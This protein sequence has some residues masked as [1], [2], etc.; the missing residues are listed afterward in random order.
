MMKMAQIEPSRE[1][2][3]RY[4][5]GEL[6]EDETRSADERFFSDETFALMVDETYR[7]LV[8]AYSANEIGGSEKERVERAFFSEPRRAHQL[9][10][11]QALRSLPQKAARVA[12]RASSPWFL[13]FWPVATKNYRHARTR[14]RRQ[15]TLPRI[16]LQQA[17]PRR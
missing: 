13:S 9:E 5:L 16:R 17:R 10:V 8:D 2:L 1:W 11:L 6:S 4:V 7:D 14:M 12:P 3:V 15:N